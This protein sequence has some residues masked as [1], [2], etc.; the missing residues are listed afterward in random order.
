MSELAPDQ[1]PEGWS[2][3]AEVYDQAFVSMT[4]Q[5]AEAALQQLDIQPGESVL[6]VATGTGVFALAAAARGARVLATDF[7]PGMIERLQAHVRQS[8]IDNIETA[9]MDGQNLLLD[10]HSF[11][12]AASIVG[13]IFF[14]DI[15]RGVAEMKRV[16]KPGGRCAIVCWG[17]M[18]KFQMMHYLRRAIGIAVPQ[19]EMP[20]ATP[21]WARLLG[22]DALQQCL[23]RGGFS[24]V[25]VTRIE[26]V[27]EVPSPMQY[28]QN[29]TSS[30]PPLQRLF[31]QLGED[32]TRRVGEVFAELIVADAGG[33]VPRLSAE[34]CVG[35]GVA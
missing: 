18:E 29:F 20:D 28:W 30:A 22:H 9:V 14:P 13:V 21:V 2:N 15:E 23:Q 33:A 35:V 12:V 16:L 3:I 1:L 5:L 34:A 25:A 17:E 10:D 8:A 32:N 27:H 19:F 7:A 31:R 6:D 26:A 4:S 24:N 11:D